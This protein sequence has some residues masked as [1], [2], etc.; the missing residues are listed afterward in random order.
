MLQRA[1]PNRKSQDMAGRVNTNGNGMLPSGYGVLLLHVDSPGGIG[2][3]MDIG[4]EAQNSHRW[5]REEKFTTH[6]SGWHCPGELECIG[7]SKS[8]RECLIDSL[9]GEL[10]NLG[11]NGIA[12]QFGSQT[13]SWI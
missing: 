8:G 7:C 5:R 12:S 2:D 11:S 9:A 1:V 3:H 4:F 10:D 6:R 13:R